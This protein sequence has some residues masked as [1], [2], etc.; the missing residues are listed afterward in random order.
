[1]TPSAEPVP[2]YKLITIIVCSLMGVVFIMTVGVMMYKRKVLR[3]RSAVA[4]PT[5]EKI[6]KYMEQEEG[7][8]GGKGGYLKKK[9]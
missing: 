7:I 4:P 2:A 8:D 3:S 6:R 1:M 5:P 9:L